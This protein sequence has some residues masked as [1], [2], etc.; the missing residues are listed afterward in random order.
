[1]DSLAGVVLVAAVWAAAAEVEAGPIPPPVEVD[2]DLACNVVVG[3]LVD[4]GDP[5]DGRGDGV[6]YGQATV[7]VTE[8]LKG[9]PRESVDFRTIAFVPA[10]WGGAAPLRAH[11]VG[12][13]GIWIIRDGGGVLFDTGLVPESRKDKVCEMLVMLAGRKW[14]S[15][16]N[17][18]QAWAGVVLPEHARNPE[19][20]FAVKNVTDHDLFVP[21]VHSADFVVAT[22]AGVDGRTTEY[23]FGIVGRA[24]ESVFCQRL[25]AGRTA[26]L[27]P[28]VSAI[29][30]VGRHNLPPGDYSVVI[31]CQNAKRGRISAGPPGRSKEVD[32][33]T[34]SLKAPAVQFSCRPREAGIVQTR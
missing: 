23:S 26:Y 31:R 19:I 22:V 27:H 25:A 20:I 32:A 24:S 34:G 7:A 15:P 5:G 29:D 10:N 8:T 11:K 2:L 14:S 28:Y 16:V 9:P 21:I 4:L 18:L 17:G 6:R 12:D 1:M 13:A 33:W 3:R 30:L